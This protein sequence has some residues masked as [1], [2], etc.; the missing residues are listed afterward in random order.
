MAFLMIPLQGMAE[1]F[2][3]GLTI[4]STPGVN[5]VVALANMGNHYI[6]FAG[7][8]WMHVVEYGGFQCV[9]SYIWYIYFCHDVLSYAD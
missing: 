9:N 5:P 8:L 3:Q 1:I 6:N 4:I 7:N 2:R